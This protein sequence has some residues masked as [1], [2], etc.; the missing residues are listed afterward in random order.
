MYS[1]ISID[2]GGMMG[3][4]PCTILSHI[5]KQIQNLG[6]D[7]SIRLAQCIDFFAGTSTG[8]IMA[9]ALTTPDEK[10][11]PKFTVE[12]LLDF[13]RVSG[14]EI[15]SSKLL[16]KISSGFGLRDSKYDDT[17]LIE[18]MKKYFGS[19]KVSDS[20]APSLVTAYDLNAQEAHYFKSYTAKNNHQ[21]DYYRRD[22]ARAT[23]SAPT[24]FPLAEVNNLT[25]DETR[26][27]VD[28]VMLAYNP[29]LIAYSE[30][31]RL[32]QGAGSKNMNLISLGTG[33]RALN[34][35]SEEAK[36]WGSINWGSNFASIMIDGNRQ[37]VHNQLTQVFAD[38]PYNYTR[39]NPPLLDTV[40]TSLDNA[41]AEN[42]EALMATGHQYIEDNKQQLNS[43]A[44]RLYDEAFHPENKV[45][46]KGLGIE[47]K[48]YWL[49]SYPATA[50]ADIDV[51][52]YK[53]LIEILDEA[54]LKFADRIA[55]EN[56]GV[57]LTYSHVKRYSEQVAFWLQSQRLE[58][59]DRVA[60]MMPNCLSY[61]II[62]QAILKSGMIAV[63]IN[64]LYTSSELDHVI[65]D[66]GCKVI[67]IWEGAANVLQQAKYKNAIES[68]VI[69]KLTDYF[70]PIKR[71][72]FNYAS[73]YIKRIIP[74]Y[75]LDNFICMPKIIAQTRGKY[76]F[77]VHIEAEDIAFLQYTG[78]T[79]GV[80]KGAMIT[81]R[82][83][84]ATV[85]QTREI[86]DPELVNS[87]QQLSILTPLP[88][89]HIFA[90]SVSS[91]FGY[92]LGMRN[93]LIANP[94][95]L[96]SMFEVIKKHSL[97]LIIG[98]NTLYNAMLEHPKFTS[99]DWSQLKT[100][101]SGGMAL[102]ESTA[103]KWAKITGVSIAE[104]YGL[105]ETS[106]GAT[107]TSYE[108]KTFT[109]SVGLPMPSTQIMI[110]DEFG[111]PLAQ[112]ETGE[113]CIRGPQVMKGYWKLSK[114]QNNS[115]TS[116]HWL[117]TGDMGRFDEK[118][119]LYI[120]DRLKDMILVSG[121][122]VFPN[123]IEGVI[124]QHPDVLESACIGIDNEKSGE[125]VKAFV[126]LTGDA[127]I[128][129]TEL[130]NWC[131]EKLTAYKIPQQFQFVNELPKSNVG[132]IL[133][134]ELRKR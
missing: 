12:E 78:G 122:N 65:H 111:N 76:P 116:K 75:Q 5:E 81:Q 69:C 130:Q 31:R 114:N 38:N 124:D 121:F 104:G 87:Q 40:K 29:G 44:K 47:P 83:M 22:A 77:G 26:L 37:N 9:L 32:S 35:D 97:S 60:I 21:Y 95:D 120:V 27:C 42:I 25:G 33:S 1:I 106:S 54:S 62:F 94:K 45:F 110:A 46:F 70:P 85:R 3:I 19:L 133:R 61:P 13:Y 36:Q 72:L 93:I 103:S 28:G 55:Y 59:D 66:S 34:I 119:Q 89:Y 112:G 127:N 50:K 20:V 53:N 57:T 134:R 30:F 16:R 113:I 125:V 132:K 4:V 102:R 73:K 49:N 51:S 23:A 128:S 84:I 82:N 109:G 71:F 118:G 92:S 80:S 2:G 64:P 63:N 100:A 17:A 7:D 126:V 101:L 41:T 131:R 67:F 108:T 39:I 115:I 24:F 11:K 91:I 96:N 8:G 15:F 79:T 14:P 90:L 74:G 123:E 88:L 68:I 48:A 18:V 86:A 43:I 107:F 52:Q 10:G 105:T 56:F 98:V 6:N 58:S 99:M 129:E 117:R